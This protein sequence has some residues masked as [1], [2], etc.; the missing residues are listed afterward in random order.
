[1]ATVFPT[2]LIVHQTILSGAEQAMSRRESVAKNS[3]HTAEVLLASRLV[4]KGM[5]MNRLIYIVGL[6]VVVLAVLA[7]FGF[8]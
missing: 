2:P 5:V 3:Q 7:F 8:R 4:T 6:V 1:M